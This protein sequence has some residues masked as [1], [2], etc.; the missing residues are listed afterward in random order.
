MFARNSARR[1]FLK[2]S[3]AGVVGAAL[4]Q[5]SSAEGITTAAANSRRKEFSVRAF[6]AKGDGHTIDTA[7]IN[8]AIDAAGVDG[9]TVIFP[10]GSYLSYGYDPPEPNQ[11]DKYQDFGYSHWHN[12][13]IWGEGLS[14]F[15]FLGPV[16]FG[17]VGLVGAR[18]MPCS[19]WGW[20]TKQSA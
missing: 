4:T 7:P 10:A 12:S 11:W 15:Q 14:K 16:Y 19:R 20:E 13:L 8:R 17:D 9:G 3:G 6:G 5:N 1:D 2:L 18:E